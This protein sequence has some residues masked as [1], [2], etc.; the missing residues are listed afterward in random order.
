V[1]H[2]QNLNSNDI[3]TVV[4]EQIEIFQKHRAQVQDMAA[5]DKTYVLAASTY[6]LPCMYALL[7]AFLYTGRSRIDGNQNERLQHNDRYA[8]AFIF[9]ATIS[10]FSSL[11]PKD[12]LLSPLAVAFLAGYS[13]D[14]FTAHLDAL[15]EKMKPHHLAEEP[16]SGSFTHG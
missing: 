15:V 16:Q 4:I 10:L 5:L 14:V 2:P 9:G 11:I 12:V 1:V 13:I 3:K 8:M 7:G 6:I